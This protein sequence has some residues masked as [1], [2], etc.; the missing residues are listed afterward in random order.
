MNRPRS[1][2]V[3]TRAHGPTDLAGIQRLAFSVISRSLDANWSTQQTWS[4]GRPTAEVIETI[5]KPNDRLSS[6]ERL[7]IYNK[8]YWF[9]L[10]DCLYDDFP[11]LL[12]ILGQ[13]RFAK[14]VR[15]YLAECPSRSFT[16][17]NLGDRLPEFIAAHPEMA[18]RRMR[19]VLDMARFEWAQIVAFDGKAEAPVAVDDLLGKDPRRLRLGLQPYLTVLDLAYPLDDYS[20]A[21]KKN[22]LRGSASNAVGA[23]QAQADTRVQPPK[24][25]RTFVVVHRHDNANYFKRLDGREYALLCELRDGQT[26]AAACDV[27]YGGAAPDEAAAAIRDAFQTW[28]SLGWFCKRGG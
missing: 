23:P 4:D 22:A 13:T 14:L 10:I 19:M 18:G 27:A 11:G 12:A 26:L 25:R 2:P 16:L 15:D 5:I 7:E 9:R 24:P 17:R 28:S 3:E 20:L 21:L 6:F 1:K 8:Q